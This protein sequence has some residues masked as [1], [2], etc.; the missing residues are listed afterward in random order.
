MAELGG[1]SPQG[2]LVACFDAPNGTSLEEALRSHDKWLQRTFEW[3][4][5]STRMVLSVHPYQ[6][7]EATET[8]QARSLYLCAS[9]RSFVLCASCFVLCA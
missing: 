8:F 3:D 5:V 1:L 9:F 6:L 7:M 4:G 2:I